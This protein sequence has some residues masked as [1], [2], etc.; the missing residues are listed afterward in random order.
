MYCMHDT[1]LELHRILCKHPTC[2]SDITQETV[3]NVRISHVES[4]M[5]CALLVVPSL[6]AMWKTSN[7][8]REILGVLDLTISSS[9]FQPCFLYRHRLVNFAL[10][11]KVTPRWNF[12]L[13]LQTH[14]GTAPPFAR[15]RHRRSQQVQQE[16]LKYPI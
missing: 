2:I 14:A 11:V 1:A 3:H 6:E 16:R 12:S 4:K 7:G 8:D 9:S 15:L 13:R 5:G 10:H